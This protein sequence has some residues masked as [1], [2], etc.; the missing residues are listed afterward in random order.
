M[1]KSKYKSAKL[2]HYGGPKASSPF[3]ENKVMFLPPP[4]LCPIL[5]LK[6]SGLKGFIPVALTLLC[7]P[8]SLF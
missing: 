1:Q 6:H 4:D 2:G 7:D 8:Q 3:K 5:S